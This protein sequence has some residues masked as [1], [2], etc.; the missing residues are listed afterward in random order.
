M[1]VFT[2]NYKP[3]IAIIGDIVD[4][5]KIPDRMAIQ[6]K[7]ASVLC[8]IS[9]TYSKDISASFMITLGD[10]FQGLLNNGKF[11]IEIVEKIE[12]EMYPVKIRF[13]IGVGEITTVINRNA[14]LGADGSAYYNARKVITELKMNEKRN[15][16]SKSNIKIEIDNNENISEVLNA[17]FA[18]N[19]VIK[20]KWTTRQREIINIY[21]QCAATQSKVAEKLKI[22]Q[23]NV[24]KALSS[25]NFYTYQESISIVSKVL[26]NIKG[27]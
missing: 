8:K 27:D 1:K 11:V 4:S 19:T 6:D 10:E 13:G 24:Q 21:L 2:F 26:S 17:I 22:N 9:E 14:P 7:L 15:K 3:Y 5:K 12:R 25:S 16:E 23:S 18:L 20:K